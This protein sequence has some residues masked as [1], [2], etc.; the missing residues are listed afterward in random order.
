MQTVIQVSCLYVCLCATGVPSACGGQE[1]VSE[2][3]GLELR[4]VVSHHG[5]SAFFLLFILKQSLAK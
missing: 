3:L 1:R 5:G 4:V 2:P